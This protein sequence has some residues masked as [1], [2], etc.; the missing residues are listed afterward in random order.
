MASMSINR[1]GHHDRARRDGAVPGAAASK[2]MA[3]HAFYLGTELM[4]AEI[5]FVLGKRYVQDEPLDWG[6]ATGTCARRST[7]LPRPGHTLSGERRGRDAD[8][9]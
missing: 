8:D 1:D 4:K 2:A 3:P 9:P 7:R 5:A 6:V